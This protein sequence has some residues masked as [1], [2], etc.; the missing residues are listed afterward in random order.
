LRLHN[1]V[2][3]NSNDKDE[4]WRQR[5]L[6][7]VV[8]VAATAMALAVVIA[9]LW[10]T[11]QTALGLGTNIPNQYGAAAIVALICAVIGLLV[12]FVAEKLED[13]HSNVEEL[14]L[15]TSVPC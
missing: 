8:F 2:V 13:M 9:L 14:P 7:K 12:Y 4:N 11:I 6:A 10:P 3:A 5:P 15:C 1:G